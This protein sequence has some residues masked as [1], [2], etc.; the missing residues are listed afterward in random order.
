MAT[1]HQGDQ[2]FSAESR[3]RQCTAMATTAALY[4]TEKP[5]A[6]WT[7]MDLDLI[8]LSGD[9]LYTEVIQERPG[10]EHGYLLISDIP[11]QVTVFNK[12]YTIQRT[13]A[14]C[15]LITLQQMSEAAM[16]LENALRRVFMEKSTAI[17]ITKDSS[18]MVC[19][20][21]DG[22]VFVFD[23]HSRGENGMPVPD[24]KAVLMKL[25]DQ[26]DLLHYLREIGAVHADGGSV[27]TFEIV[28][29]SAATGP[30]PATEPPATRPPQGDKPPS[31]TGPPLAAKPTT[32]GEPSSA[33]GPTQL[34][35]GVQVAFQ[36]FLIVIK[37]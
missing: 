29:I 3:G 26:D 36:K 12:T 2:L 21:K 1:Y 37:S 15:G 25:K 33:P 17:M 14:M 9:V 7:K 22:K 35:N 27:A 16:S 6:E 30:S 24:G 31:A 4:A 5:V 32:A 18:V 8:L 28:G 19:K 34:I 20:D 11:E 13:A 23:S 10:N